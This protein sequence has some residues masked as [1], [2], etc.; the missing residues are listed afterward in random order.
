[1]QMGL[2]PEESG[3]HLSDQMLVVEPSP[4]RL[5]RPR[6]STYLPFRIAHQVCKQFFFLVA[7]TNSPLWKYL[8]FRTLAHREFG[9]VI[10][11]HPCLNIKGLKIFEAHA[12]HKFGLCDLRPS[13]L[14]HL[15]FL[16][17]YTPPEYCNR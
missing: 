4:V 11:L 12:T 17:V 3:M 6:S 7:F 10:S 15:P 13:S 9:L 1:L 5:I 16:W 14:A 2:P 8:P